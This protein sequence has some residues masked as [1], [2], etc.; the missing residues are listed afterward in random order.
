MKCQIT[1]L[2]ENMEYLAEFTIDLNDEKANTNVTE[3]SFTDKNI[4]LDVYNFIVG[5]YWKNYTPNVEIG[6]IMNTE[7]AG[8]IQFY[9][10]GTD[11]IYVNSEKN[12]YV[13]NYINAKYSFEIT[14]QNGNLINDRFGQNISLISDGSSNMILVKNLDNVTS[15]NIKVYEVKIDTLIGNKIIEINKK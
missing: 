7:L 12:G 9:G 15:L 13:T 1:V 2:Q 8:I 11:E 5:D 14:D 6:R 10:N 4:E 3:Y